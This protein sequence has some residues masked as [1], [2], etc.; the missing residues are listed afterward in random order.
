MRFSLRAPACLS[1]ACL[2]LA[3]LAL[4]GCDNAP[5]PSEPAANAAPEGPTGVS[6]ADAR[7]VLPAVKGNPAAV[8][9]DLG[10][11]GGSELAIA[12]IAVQGAKSASIHHT[13][14]GANGTSMSEAPAQVI[15]PGQVLRFEPGKLHVMASELE[16]SLAAGD[17]T[18]VT[19]TFAN[20]DK[21]S[22][23]AMVKSA[24]DAR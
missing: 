15:K 7:L 17:E 16:D 22:F 5:A 3:A 9:F 1:H 10:L 14:T 4:T 23:A 13:V 20:G 2:A 21:F 11:N 12:G 8:Y 19:L 6:V 18:E 24:G